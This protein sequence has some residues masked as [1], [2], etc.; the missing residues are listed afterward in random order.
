MLEATNSYSPNSSATTTMSKTLENRRANLKAISTLLG[1]SKELSQR[2]GYAN[3][4]YVI[5]MMNEPD[6]K[7]HR[8]VTEKRARFIEA[9]LG[10]PDES[11]NLETKDF[12]P[13]AKPTLDQLP[14]VPTARP[15]TP[16]TAARTARA[17]PTLPPVLIAVPAPSPAGAPATSVIGVR[18]GMDSVET[19]AAA[20]IR[21]VGD[22]CADEGLNLPPTKFSE[23]V[24]FALQDA[25]E[26]NGAMRQAQVKQLVRMLK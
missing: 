5:T 12:V 13:L 24:V 17:A 2:L 25:I 15:A 14:P 10:L 8:P 11:M 7:G 21:M 9:K 16:R 22:V 23:V 3:A 4:S 19:I 26:H 6:S 20:V 18:P 1:G